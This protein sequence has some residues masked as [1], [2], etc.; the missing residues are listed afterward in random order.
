MTRCTLSLNH[1]IK[2][3]SSLIY[4]AVG[5]GL[6]SSG[7]LVIKNSDNTD[8]V[9][10]FNYIYDCGTSNSAKILEDRINEYK[11]G[12]TRN[13]DLIVISH[14]DRDHVNGLEKLLNGRTVRR[15]VLPYLEPKQ[16]LSLV[17]KYYHRNRKIASM[18]FNPTA[19]F[20]DYAEEI[21]YIVDDN[22]EYNE[23]V[24]FRNNND[25]LSSS[26]REIN[27]ESMGSDFALT[28]SKAKIYNKLEL[29]FVQLVKFKFYNKAIDDSELTPFYKNV[30]I[31]LDKYGVKLDENLFKNKIV[32][33]KMK[34]LYNG[35]SYGIN[36]SSIC[37]S[38]TPEEENDRL[39]S[40]NS[41]C[42]MSIIMG[43]GCFHKPCMQR[44]GYMFTGD[45]SFNDTSK[46]LIYDDFINYY[47]NE[48]EL[49]SVF[50]IPHH[51]SVHNWNKDL[52][53]KFKNAEMII[54]ARGNKHHPSPVVLGD[55]SLAS[56]LNTTVNHT[57]NKEI[58]NEI[59]YK[60]YVEDKEC[61]IDEI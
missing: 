16:R 21:I 28:S 38:V 20:N 58:Y 17:L 11:K 41:K 60:T 37:M 22:K 24:E 35:L 51:G 48:R 40:A 49:M 23:E 2:L 42:L 53:S 57:L 44:F 29:K 13:F 56:R 15:L 27:K 3:E 31:V 8:Y 39:T 25:L 61:A 18:I 32:M 59:F 46:Y 12:N 54:T 1:N 14:F 47:R 52:L 34:E 6:F 9:S 45:L 50:T 43:L 36:N 10:E 4:H 26:R 7:K 30:D 19:F 55:L 5:N 33:K